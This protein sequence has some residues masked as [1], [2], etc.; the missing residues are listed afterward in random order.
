MGTQL[1]QE[2]ERPPHRVFLDAFELGAYAVSRAEYE[3]FVNATRHEPPCDWSHPPFT[4]ADLPVVGVSWNDAVAYCGVAIR[5]GRPPGAVADR[6]RVGVCRTRATAVALPL[7]RRHAGLDAQRRTRPAAGTVA[8]DARRAERLRPFRHRGQRARVVCRLVRQGLLRPITRAQ[9]RWP[10][11][12]R[13]TCRTRGSLAPRVHHL[14]SHVAQQTRS[15]LPIQRLRVSDRTKS[16]SRAGQ[17]NVPGAG[18]SR[19][20]AS[21]PFHRRRRPCGLRPSVDSVSTTTR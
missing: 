19:T 12:G 17:S 20:R 16:L 6:S 4:Q 11:Q 21:E 9:S 14:P 8:G 18:A 15:D 7:G 5:T 3:C 1:G 13:A 10:R 2:D